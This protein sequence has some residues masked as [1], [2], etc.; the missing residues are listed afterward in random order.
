MPVRGQ[1]GAGEHAAVT[2]GAMVVG[3]PQRIAAGSGLAGLVA[4]ELAKA[5]RTHVLQPQVQATMGHHLV[6]VGA[7]VIAFTAMEMRRFLWSG[8]AQDAQALL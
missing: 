1:L 3:V 4:G 6:G 5:S 8:A 7:H 2:G